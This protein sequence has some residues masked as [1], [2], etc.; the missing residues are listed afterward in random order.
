MTE[1]MNLISSD[2]EFDEGRRDKP[3]KDTEGVLTIGVGWNLDD[4]GLPDHI[5]DQLLNISIS[6]ACGDAAALI[7][8]FHSLSANRQRAMVNMAFNLGK[9]RMSSFK[10]MLSAV[11]RGQWATA[12]AEMLDSKWA[13]Q[14]GDRAVR[15]ADLMRT[16]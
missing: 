12:A 5:I 15:L 9:P 13:R 6:E 14:V 10:R 16:G 1:L 3:Y 7:D 11:N 2:L 8:G 4:R